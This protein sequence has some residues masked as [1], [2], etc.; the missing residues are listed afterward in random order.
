MKLAHELA[1][2]CLP[3]FSSKFSRH[4]FTLA[5]LFACLV[6]R[7]HM[8]LSYRRTEA[9]LRDTGWCAR[10]GMS[11]VP[12][13]ATLCR[14]FAQIV[15][16]GM[17]GDALD[18]LVDA[19]DRAEATG[20]TLAI[21]STM[22]DTHHFTRHYDYRRSK[23]AGGDLNVIN[24]RKS[25]TVRKMPKLGIGVDTR[26]HLITGVLVKTGMG[27]DAPDFHDLMIDACC[28]C[29]PRVV[30]AD[31][32]Y[33]SAKNHALARDRMGITSWIKAG[34]GRPTNKPPSDRHR[35]HMQRKLKGS[36]AG[37]PYGQRAQVETV[38]SML[39]RNLGGY[40]RSRSRFG[41]EMEMRLKTVVHN[42][43]VV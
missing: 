21:D 29:R 5:Q 27:S 39:K 31:A 13:H 6:V 17:L 43:M 35:R 41:R 42:L 11:R 18:L 36:Q 9:L 12:D 1:S 40:L 28:R 3:G 38:M 14:A 32:G 20:D 16:T 26:S 37:K 19:M 24:T 8:R 23:H 7:E 10:L 25:E 30:L 2:A 22:Y 33:D 34:V 4:D 15:M